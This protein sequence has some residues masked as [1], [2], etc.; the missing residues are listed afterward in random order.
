MLRVA[1]G[2]T[3]CGREELFGPNTHFFRLR[4]KRGSGVSETPTMEFKKE[5]NR[6]VGHTLNFEGST[7]GNMEQESMTR[8]GFDAN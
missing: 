8:S 5:R 2:N 3:W 6:I 4:T 1:S 7:D